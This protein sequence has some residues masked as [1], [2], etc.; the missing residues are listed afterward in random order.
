[1]LERRPHRFLDLLSAGASVAADTHHKAAGPVD[2]EWHRETAQFWKHAVGDDE[3]GLAASGD[4]I[5]EG[6][7]ARQVGWERPCR[8]P[9]VG[10]SRLLEQP[11]FLAVHDGRAHACH[12]FGILDS[13]AEIMPHQ[14]HRHGVQCIRGRSHDGLRPQYPRD[15]LRQ[16]VAAA[17]VAGEQADGESARV[18]D[19][20]HRW[21]GVL[22]RDHRRDQPHHHAHRP[23][24]HDGAVLAEKL[25]HQPRHAALPRV[26][27]RARPVARIAPAG[28]AC[29]QASLAGAGGPAGSPADSPLLQLL[30]GTISR[31]GLP[32]AGAVEGREP[33]WAN[34]GRARLRPSRP[35]MAHQLSPSR[36]PLPGRST[37]LLL[38]QLPGGDGGPAR[39]GGSPGGSPSPHAS[40]F[41]T[42]AP[43]R[44]PAD[45]A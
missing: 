36:W 7:A 29:S 8:G 41:W 5:F 40:P 43:D 23:E 13:P 33:G 12:C 3:G 32:S 1:M 25:G 28:R 39:R 37:R 38:P 24:D 31:M 4:Q 11:H 30:G 2:H 10:L 15:S 18:V 27:R 19:H 45:R 44:C 17:Q 26:G 35:V 22:I 34:E 16:R 14:V 20:H 42:D 21:V 6:R 9:P